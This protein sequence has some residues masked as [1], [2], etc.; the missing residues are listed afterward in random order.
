MVLL[1]ASSNGECVLILMDKCLKPKINPVTWQTGCSSSD[2]RG[3]ATTD[4]VELEQ[5]S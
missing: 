3:Y 4:S 2:A 5:P 1:L